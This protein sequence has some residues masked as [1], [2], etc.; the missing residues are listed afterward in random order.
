MYP[1]VPTTTELGH[2]K[3]LASTWYALVAPAGVPQA[4]LSKIENDVREVMK[5]GFLERHTTFE[6]WSVMAS[7]S[8]EMSRFV[9][10][11]SEAIGEMMKTAGVKPE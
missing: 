11:Q 7:T 6:G 10:S 3:L 4:V 8:E 5:N 2:P 1:D 9:S